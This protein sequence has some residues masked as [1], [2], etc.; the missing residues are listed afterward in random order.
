M[1]RWFRLYDDL[2]NNRKVQKLPPWLFRA[3]INLLCCAS[4]AHERGVLPSLEDCAFLCRCSKNRMAVIVERLIDVGLLD[5]QADGQLRPHDW[6][7]HQYEGDLSTE[8]VRKHREKMAAIGEKPYE[9]DKYRAEV[10]MR[11]GSACVY[12]G[13]TDR[14]CLDHVVPV[15]LGGWTK[16]DNLVTACKKCNSGKAG[17]TP[18]GAGLTFIN[19]QAKQLAKSAIEKWETAIGN[20]GTVTETAPDPETEVDPETD[21]EEIPIEQSTAD[22]GG[23]P[24]IEKSDRTI[25]ALPDELQTPKFVAAWR[26]FLAHC[27]QKNRRVTPL[28]RGRLLAQCE[29]LGPERAVAAIEHSIASGWTKLVEPDGARATENYPQIIARHQKSDPQRVR[30]YEAEYAMQ[31]RANGSAGRLWPKNQWL[32]YHLERG[33]FD[34]VPQGVG[35]S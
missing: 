32:A 35:A 6:E 13:S 17:R 7:E 16:P 9:R 14:L 19:E 1:A 4:K 5:R 20:N 25:E 23:E 22:A 31:E 30:R 29:Q 12:C 3:W 33:T 10:F 34:Q 15:T 18:E 21:T 8:R 24:E 2:L 27:G 26:D 11:D 28:Q